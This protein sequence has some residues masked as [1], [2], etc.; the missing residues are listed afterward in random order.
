MSGAA[1]APA[2]EAPGAG[3]TATEPPAATVEQRIQSFLR[4]NAGLLKPGSIRRYTLAGRYICAVDGQRP[5]NEVKA[6]IFE[7][8]PQRRREW[9]AAN[10]ADVSD[11]EIEVELSVYTQAVLHGLDVEQAAAAMEVAVSTLYKWND[12][13]FLVPSIAAPQI[14]RL[15]KGRSGPKRRRLG[16]YSQADIRLGRALKRLR[17]DKM[18]TQWFRHAMPLLRQSR[19]LLYDRGDRILYER[20][21]NGDL[22]QVWPV[23]SRQPRTRAL[24]S[25]VLDWTLEEL[26]VEFEASDT[27]RKKHR[28]RRGV[29]KGRMKNY[30]LPAFGGKLVRDVTRAAVQDELAR[31]ARED[32][33]VNSRDTAVQLLRD[34][35]HVLKF[36]S[37]RLGK[38]RIPDFAPKPAPASAQDE[39]EQRLGRLRQ[40]HQIYV[41]LKEL[42]SVEDLSECK[43]A[44]LN[45]GVWPWPLAELV[46]AHFSPALRTREALMLR[47]QQFDK[48]AIELGEKWVSRNIGGTQSG[49]LSPHAQRTIPPGRWLR[50]SVVNRWAK[51]KAGEDPVFANPKTAKQADNIARIGRLPPKPYGRNFLLAYGLKPVA[52]KLAEKLGEEWALWKW[53]SWKA[54]RAEGIYWLEKRLQSR[55]PDKWQ[56]ALAQLLGEKRRGPDVAIAELAPVVDEL[57][58]YLVEGKEPAIEAA[59]APAGEPVMMA[60]ERL[61]D[62][63]QLMLVLHDNNLEPLDAS[64]EME[65]DLATVYRYTAGK[66]PGPY[67]KKRVLKAFLVKHR[68][69]T[70]IE[71]E[72]LTRIVRIFRPERAKQLKKIYNP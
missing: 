51:G 34:L 53:V 41:R 14:E 63:D 52:A 49:D 2:R 72:E 42:E 50:E 65:V 64:V 68:R 32:D 9:A 38:V 66:K 71:L 69:R 31:L 56:A 28:D 17:D 58:S 43:A 39:R 23:E 6:A 12:K 55:M 10:K 5:A 20:F 46:L 36:K 61:E 16:L 13:G 40:I 24:P 62:C 19:D 33:R 18:P 47:C 4:E 35:Q 30:W 27:F 25:D 11:A 29:L 45:L 3:P 1:A 60:V 8:Y 59:A 7:S 44:G 57:Q 48:D 70:E 21:L 26:W 54:I 22:R 67:K 15:R 37:I